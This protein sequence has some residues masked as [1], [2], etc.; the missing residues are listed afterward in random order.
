MTIFSGLDPREFAYSTFTHTLA[1]VG[2][3]TISCE[4]QWMVSRIQC[5]AGAN[6]ATVNVGGGAVPI[7]ANGCLI[8]EPGGLLRRSILATG[9]GMQIVIEYFFQGN[10]SA[11]VPTVTVV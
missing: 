4:Q 9:I 5:F 1:G 11:T 8:L 3:H 7:A 6:A 10:P 2:T